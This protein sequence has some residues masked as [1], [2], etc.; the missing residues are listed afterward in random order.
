MKHH[1]ILSENS[2]HHW[3]LLDTAGKVLLDL[4]CGRHDTYDL[5]Q[6]SAV[7]LGEKGATKVIAIDGNPSE[8]H[9]F[10]TNNPDLDKYTFLH[11]FINNADDIRELLQKYNP[12]VIKCDIE[13]YETAF[14][15]ITAEEL[16]NVTDIAI[17]YHNINIL[18]NITQ[19]LI[20]WGFTINARANFA[21]VSA[22]QMGVLFC[23]KNG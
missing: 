6:S 7:Y 10:N 19:K 11:K 9:Y 22:P 5:Y 1:D 20:E 23:S 21:F 14:Y 8:I 18:V 2:E 4:G 12:S 17:E 3:P 16:S 15:D 13:E